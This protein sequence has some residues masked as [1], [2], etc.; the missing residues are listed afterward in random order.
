MAVELAY[1]LEEREL[2]Y[3]SQA[4]G[5]LHLVANNYR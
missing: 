2:A 4:Y 5:M 1:P 3:D